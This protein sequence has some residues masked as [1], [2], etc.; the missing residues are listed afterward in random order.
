MGAILFKLVNYYQPQQILELG[1]ALGMGTLYMALAAPESA[2]V[3]TIEGNPALDC[4]STESISKN[5]MLKTLSLIEGTFESQ[6]TPLS[7]KS[8]SP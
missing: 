6:L 8:R 7:T 2:T 4:G 3:Y 1:T 5:W